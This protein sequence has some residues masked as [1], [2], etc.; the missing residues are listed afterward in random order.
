MFEY[1]YQCSKN[2][3]LKDIIH[4]GET[5]NKYKNIID[6]LPKELETIK[7]ISFLCENILEPVQKEFGKIILTYGFAS[8]DLTK[9][10]KSRIY[11]KLDQHSGYEKNKKGNYICERLGQAVDFYIPNINS[12]NICKWINLNCQFDRMYFY[13]EEIR[14]FKLKFMYVQL[15]LHERAFFGHVI[16]LQSKY[17]WYR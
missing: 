13:G 15:I 6:N 16:F 1:N 10:I 2:F 8:Y 17:W 9:K 14:Q 12:K 7:A 3:K 11:S 4:C 5:W